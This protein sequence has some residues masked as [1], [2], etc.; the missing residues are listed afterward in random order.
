ML[1]DAVCI[2]QLRF[3]SMLPCILTRRSCLVGTAFCCWPEG[4]STS[5]YGGSVP[6]SRAS[7]MQ[8]VMGKGAVSHSYCCFHCY[9][10]I[11]QAPVSDMLFLR[12]KSE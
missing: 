12:Y 8:F 3:T 11:H 2:S 4:S 9:I 6:C 5:A 10:S 7:L 1:T